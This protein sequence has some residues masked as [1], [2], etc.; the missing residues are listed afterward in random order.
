MPIRYVWGLV[1]IAIG[2]G[3]IIAVEK[4]LMFDSVTDKV[5]SIQVGKPPSGTSH[6]RVT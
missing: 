5:D 1:G 6:P 2:I 3:V 4:P